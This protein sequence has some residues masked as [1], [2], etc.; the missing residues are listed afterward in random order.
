MKER[1]KDA[2]SAYNTLIN[3]VMLIGIDKK[4]KGEELTDADV[5]TAVVKVEK[6]LIEERDAF[7]KAG[8]EES[9]ASLNNQISAIS[10]YKPVTISE[11]RIREIILSLPTRAIPDVMKYFKTNY[12]GQVDMKVVNT[13]LRSMN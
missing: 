11:E 6:E 5:Y 8:R 2:V 9:V 7:A 12:A 3:K 4:S 1:N 13:V 10:V